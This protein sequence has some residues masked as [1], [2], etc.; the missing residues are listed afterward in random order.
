MT[1]CFAAVAVSLAL[2]LI[3]LSRL[4]A[5]SL[6]DALCAAAEKGDLPAVEMVLKQGANINAKDA[7]GY[8]ALMNAT[9][10]G[11]V[12]IVK[13]LVGQ[14]AGLE[15]KDTFG[16]RTAL[17]LAVRRGADK[18]D[19][20]ASYQA[21]KLLLENGA[22]TDCLFQI[23]ITPL[24]LVCRDGDL[25]MA[26]LLIKHG[27][28]IY[29]KDEFGN[30][31][32]TWAQKKGHTEIVRALEGLE[33]GTSPPTQQSTQ[34][35][36]KLSPKALGYKRGVMESALE[37]AGLVPPEHADA[38]PSSEAKKNAEPYSLAGKGFRL[39]RRTVAVDS[40]RLDRE[41]FSAAMAARSGQ[42]ADWQSLWSVAKA[43]NRVLELPPGTRV[44]VTGKAT[45]IRGQVTVHGIQGT[46]W[47]SAE[48]F[49]LAKIPLPPNNYSK[50][51]DEEDT[52]A[53]DD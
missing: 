17:M 47:I 32:L 51:M 30:T 15:I 14:K 40:L 46:W 43:Q 11:R 10:G 42:Q 24:M 4:H 53:H 39:A 7:R 20:I 3:P 44:T 34:T 1:R 13:Y 33:A 45:G 21:A 48:D 26:Q 12:K 41:L 52:A 37:E 5:D 16:E 27:A 29:A 25:E 2:T 35:R 31:P 8:T 18:E 19:R 23:G 28:D 36:E 38:V 50:W 22:R 49:N 6:S 9:F